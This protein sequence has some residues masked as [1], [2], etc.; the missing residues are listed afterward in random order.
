MKRNVFKVMAMAFAMSLVLIF[1]ACGSGST[2]LEQWLTSSEAQEVE[3]LMSSDG[4]KVELLSES[5]NILI[6]R[7]TYEEAL[8]VS[9]SEL[10]PLLDEALNAQASLFTTQRDTLREELN[11]SDLKIRIV[12]CSSDGSEITSKDF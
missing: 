4:I 9:N 12:Y 2:A 3:S 7:F 5:G 10:K 8:D 11:M 6:F 1:T